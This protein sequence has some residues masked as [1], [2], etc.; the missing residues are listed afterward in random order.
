M[1]L[2]GEKE[3][4]ICLLYYQYVLIFIQIENR[5]SGGENGFMIRKYKTYFFGE[6]PYIYIYIYIYSHFMECFP[7]NCEC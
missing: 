4:F 5:D 7:Q 1:Q 2:T 6:V 3:M